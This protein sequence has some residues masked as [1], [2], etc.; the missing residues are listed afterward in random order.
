LPL[1]REAVEDLAARIGPNDNAFPELARI[2]ARYRSAIASSEQA[3]SWGLVWGLG[4][5][6]EETAAAAERQIDRLTPALEDAAHA[7]LQAWR[8]LHAPLILATAEGR[9]LQGQA[10]ELRM[11]RWRGRRRGRAEPISR[12]PS[13][14]VDRTPT[15]QRRCQQRLDD[16]RQ[17]R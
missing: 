6:L 17:L 7:A 2:L 10:D 9:E 5:R 4:V 8:T 3:I 1:V 16:L 15:D 12:G 11:T 14:P 13:H